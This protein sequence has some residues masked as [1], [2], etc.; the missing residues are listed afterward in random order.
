MFTSTAQTSNAMIKTLRS[1]AALIEGLLLD[2]NLIVMTGR[3][4]SNP[5]ERRISQYHQMSWGCFLVSL[6]EVYNSKRVSACR[7][8]IKENINFWNED[9]SMEEYNEEI[10]KHLADIQPCSD[11][12]L[13]CNLSEEMATTIAGYITKKLVKHSKGNDCKT[14]LSA[15][16]VE[17]ST[18]HY[19]SLLS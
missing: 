4:Q 6:R 9:F 12:I 17:I 5:I 8:L 16:D 19:L 10:K 11:E 15:K 1:Q 3:L 14:M 18:N 13:M 7:S 2:G